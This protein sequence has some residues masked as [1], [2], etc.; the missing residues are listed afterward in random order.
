MSQTF[1]HGG[2]HWYAVE[3]DASNPVGFDFA[4]RHV[5]YAFLCVTRFAGFSREMRVRGVT[6][7][8]YCSSRISRFRWRT[9]A[10]GCSTSMSAFCDDFTHGISWSTKICSG[11]HVN[12]LAS[13]CWFLLLLTLLDRSVSASKVGS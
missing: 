9:F 2:C 1:P 11:K 6:W 5:T 7:E 10:L 3:L 13:I 8:R 4:W 12:T